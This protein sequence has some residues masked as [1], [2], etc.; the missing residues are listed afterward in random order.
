MPEPGGPMGS[1]AQRSYDSHVDSTLMA[2]QPSGDCTTGGR[3]RQKMEKECKR[4]RCAPSLDR[5]CGAPFLC[6]GRVLPQEHAVRRGGL[7]AYLGAGERGDGL[8]GDGHAPADG[9]ENVAAPLAAGLGIA[10]ARVVS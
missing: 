7:R 3:R 2:S 5:A 4:E 1:Q 6:E 8:A 10:A 9:G